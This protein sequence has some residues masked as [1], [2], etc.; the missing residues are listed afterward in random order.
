M[1]VAS[2]NHLLLLHGVLQ[3]V[4]LHTLARF[5]RPLPNYEVVAICGPSASAA[6]SRLRAVVGGQNASLITCCILDE[7]WLSMGL[8]LLLCVVLVVHESFLFLA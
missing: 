6:L 3:L 7:L 5:C 4:V 2:V 1:S 8:L